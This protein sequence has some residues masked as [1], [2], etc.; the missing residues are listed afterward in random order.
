MKTLCFVLFLFFVV[1]SL[2]AQERIV[3]PGDI[4]FIAV[5]GQENLSGMV[6][7]GPDGTLSLFP[8]VGILQVSGMTISQ[9]SELLTNRLS[10]TIRNPRVTVSLHAQEG[11]TVHVLGEVRAP[12]FYKVPENTTVQEVITR[13]G[14]Q[15][16]Q[17]DLTRIRLR[18]KD[19]LQVEDQISRKNGEVTETIIDLTRFIFQ[20]DLSENPALLAEDVL[21]IPR[22][23]RE[24]RASKLITVLGSVRTPG[25]YEVEGALPLLEVL[26]LAHGAAPNA[27]LKS[28]WILFP[29]PESAP[30]VEEQPKPLESQEE[31]YEPKQISLEGYLTGKGA[32]NNPLISPGMVVFVPSTLLPPERPFFVNV[33]GQVNRTGAYPIKEGTRLLDAISSAGGFGESALIDQITILHTE[34]KSPT[35]ITVDLTKYFREEDL[36]SNPELYK[37]DTIIVP[38]S[39]AAI[40][41]SSIQSV[42]S[43]SMTLHAIGEVRLPGSYQLTA[44]ASL[45]N[46]LSIAG[47]P[48]TD[49]DLERVTILRESEGQTTQLVVDLR[50]VLE[51][52][53]FDLL[54][55]L[56][57]QDT[58]FIPKQRERRNF[59][60]TLVGIA[61]DLTAIGI[62]VLIIIEG[63]RI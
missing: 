19:D 40:K 10:E 15:T 17:A 57:P 14:G 2:N 29:K 26:A 38:V 27:D 33:V 45:L 3:A 59:W 63:R 18:R 1:I 58:I 4:L 54:P 56:S 55:T 37:G 31:I 61:R 13:A 44:S 12:S 11:F 6:T 8:P 16:E 34:P 23:S 20:G 22:L 60:R 21:I 32:S 53:E 51:E 7:V 49:A 35:S 62:A 5:W 52:G 48:T 42:F 30:V 46:V 24:E 28:V 41:M 9:I 43:P 25:A 36:G 47:G 39:K 50:R